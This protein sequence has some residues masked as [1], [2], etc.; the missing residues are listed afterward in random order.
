MVNKVTLIGRLG[1]DPEVRRLESGAVVAKFSIA[2]SERYRDKNDE[3]QE[4]TEWHDCVVWRYLA[5]RAERDLKKGK[6]VYLEG[7][8]THRKYQTAEGQ[9]R[10]ITEVVG[11]TFR[12]L[13]RREDSGFSNNFPSSSDEPSSFKQTSNTG[14]ETAQATPSTPPSQQ[15]EVSEASGDDLPF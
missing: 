1:K 4:Q 2:T 15:E 6:L 13:E 3:W 9:N 11:N 8:L 7:K 5:E 14:G 12:L 10:Y